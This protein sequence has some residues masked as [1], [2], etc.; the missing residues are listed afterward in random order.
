M[1][2]LLPALRDSSILHCV[3]KLLFFV[4][5]SHIVAL[6]FSLISCYSKT[7]VFVKSFHSFVKE[8]FESVSVS[9]TITYFDI[10]QRLIININVFIV[11]NIL[12]CYGYKYPLYYLGNRFLILTHKIYKNTMKYIL[13]YLVLKC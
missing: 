10:Y 12:F 4:S 11:V 7:H 8:I 5:I 2:L 3:I 13:Y 9:Y 1:L 6:G